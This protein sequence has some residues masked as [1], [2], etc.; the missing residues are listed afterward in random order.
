MNQAR[1]EALFSRHLD[2]S[3][4][5]G[6]ESELMRM[7]D[8][9]MSEPAV[10]DMIGD[11]WERWLAGERQAPKHPEALYGSIREQIGAEGGE[12]VES[13]RLN[14]RAAACAVAA[15]FLS[16]AACIALGRFS[17]ANHLRARTA[18]RLHARAAT[19]T[20]TSPVPDTSAKRR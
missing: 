11:H 7:L 8:D 15:L 18:S 19:A 2:D 3:L 20:S 10:K 17:A 1:F 4:T 6:E 9:R 14:R 13:R 16:A 5:K 12:G